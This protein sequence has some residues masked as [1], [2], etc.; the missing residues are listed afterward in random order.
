MHLSVS[1]RNVWGQCAGVPKLTMNFE[2]KHDSNDVL[3]ILHVTAEM[4]AAASDQIYD[5]AK[6][7]Y[8]LGYAVLESDG[9]QIGPGL[10][11]TWMLGLALT[12]YHLQKIEEIR[13]GGDLYLVLRFTSA[14]AELEKT[15]LSKL[16]GFFSP[17]VSTAGLFGILSFQNRGV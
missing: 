11:N 4:R 14:A 2:V 12:T 1:L 9:G 16:K 8:F 3:R 13:N 7:A 10:Q 17:D 5:Y 6:S 15:D